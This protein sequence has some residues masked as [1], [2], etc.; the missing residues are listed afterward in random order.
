MVIHSVPWHSVLVKLW[1]ICP[2]QEWEGVVLVR[3]LMSR[4]VIVVGIVVIKIVI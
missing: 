2:R 3:L 4:V 1:R